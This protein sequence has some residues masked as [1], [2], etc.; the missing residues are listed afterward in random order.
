MVVNFHLAFN[1]VVAVL[2]LGPVGPLARLLSRWLP[3]PPMPADPGRP[4]HLETAALDSATVA[5]AN[6]SRETLRMADMIDLML[7]DTHK[8]MCRDD[9]ARAVVVA[10]A[11]QSVHQ[12]GEAIRRY[13]A[14]IVDEQPSD[15]QNEGA[16][17]QHILSAVINLEHV[18]DIIANSLVEYSLRNLKRG[19]RLSQ[20]EI[21][22]VSA[23]HGQ[24]LD[25]LRLALAVFLQ[26]EPGDARRLV[27]SKNDFRRF[28]TAAMALSAR[29]LRAAAAC[30]RLTESEAAASVAEESGIL[31][32]SVRDLRRIH[33]HIA[34][35]AYPILHRP[36]GSGPLQNPG[37]DPIA[38]VVTVHASSV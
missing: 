29:A 13:L 33:S 19:K 25:G 28:E 32:R 31:L 4:V 20:E 6:A 7:R 18:A 2:F 30:N 16:R 37:E 36:S 22:I 26:G 38:R 15:T 10:A 23:M 12:L 3:D 35:F 11:A 21:E 17:G 24:L 14:D 5:F 8:V 1:G 34:S 27:A 9:R